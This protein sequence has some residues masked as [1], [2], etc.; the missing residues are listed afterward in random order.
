MHVN[1]IGLSSSESLEDEGVA[2]LSDCSLV[3]CLC[4]AVCE[5]WAGSESLSGTSAC[6]L[7]L[8]LLQGGQ[9]DYN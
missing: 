2:R 1:V 8:A 4:G 9:V 3:I 6:G 5:V 7:W